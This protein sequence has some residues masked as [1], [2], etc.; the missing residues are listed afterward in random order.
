MNKKALLSHIYLPTTRLHLM[1]LNTF[2]ISEEEDAFCVYLYSFVVVIVS[3]S[4]P[5]HFLERLVGRKG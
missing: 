4:S 5:W 3:L 2:F 1:H